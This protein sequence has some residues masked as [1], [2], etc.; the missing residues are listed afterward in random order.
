MKQ[1]YSIIL[2]IGSAFLLNSCE[3]YW[4]KVQVDS[5]IL[6]YYKINDMKWYVKKQQED[7]LV[8]ETCVIG[9]QN[10]FCSAQSLRKK[11]WNVP[12]ARNFKDYDS[13]RRA[14]SDIFYTKEN[15]IGPY[16]YCVDPG[17]VSDEINEVIVS[18]D[19]AW[20]ASHPAGSSLNDLFS[21]KYASHY[22]YISSKYKESCIRTVSDNNIKI[23]YTTKK[24]SEIT[25]KD[26]LLLDR[27]SSLTFYAKRPTHSGKQTISLRLKNNSGLN[28][29]CKCSL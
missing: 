13:L 10:P 5:Y 23:G 2:I 19:V 25:S 24:L 6:S 16:S 21:I 22:P 26:L 11:K 3:K 15:T 4:D 29:E 18:S 27:G 20:D 28:I 1:F 17:A 12:T 7:S 8:L 14:Y 9:E